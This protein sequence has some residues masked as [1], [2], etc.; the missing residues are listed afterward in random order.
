M[1]EENVGET[2]ENCDPH[3]KNI[4]LST[5]ARQ[6]YRYALGA[7]LRPSHPLGV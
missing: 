3:C 7:R 4:D 5:L 1:P 6:D 2:K